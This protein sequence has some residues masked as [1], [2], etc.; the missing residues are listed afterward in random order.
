V[1]ARG[2]ALSSETHRLFH[3]VTKSETPVPTLQLVESRGFTGDA[4]GAA[5]FLG[6]KRLYLSDVFA[7]PSRRCLAIIEK[8]APLLSFEP[9]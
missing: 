9:K 3:D 8:D 2:E 4:D 6:W 7:K 5:A 1:S